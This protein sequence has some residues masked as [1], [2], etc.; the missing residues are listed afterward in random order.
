VILAPAGPGDVELLLRFRTEAAQ[1]LADRGIDQWQDPWP[2]PQGLL[3]DIARS[4]A[5]GETWILWHADVAAAT[6]TVDRTPNPGLWTPSEL[7][8]PALYAHKLTVTRA[9]ARQNLGAELLDWAGNLAAH[10]DAR[11]LR[12]DAW[13]TNQNLQRYYE[14][15]GFQH[16]RTVN[17]PHNPSGALYQRPAAEAPTPR[18]RAE[19]GRDP[20]R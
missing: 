20:S 2:S 17:L 10:T 11:W 13:T 18:I 6:I 15:L 14:R 16:L 12:L 5:A 4:V 1:W 19:R 3:D 8:E 9:H 7:A